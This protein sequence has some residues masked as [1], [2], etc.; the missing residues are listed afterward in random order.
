MFIDVPF[1]TTVALSKIR[2]W[3]F[4]RQNVD[5]KRGNM[6]TS[7]P[8]C[9]FSWS[10]ETHSTY[11]TQQSWDNSV[12]HRTSGAGGNGVSHTMRLENRTWMPRRLKASPVILGVK[13]PYIFSV[14]YMWPKQ[15]AENQI[16]VVWLLSLCFCSYVI[17][18]MLHVAFHVLQRNIVTSKQ[19][20]PS[21]CKF[22]RACWP[23]LATDR[24][25]HFTSLWVLYT[26][27]LR[28]CLSDCLA[29]AC[30]LLS[31]IKAMKLQQAASNRII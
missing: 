12:P 3:S 2:T 7:V 11:H 23:K 9:I 17:Y 25:C 28:I 16:V 27:V 24:S 4:N 20:W 10:C 26:E 31:Q 8:K 13:W 21:V 19:I 5:I 6:C 1:W 22:L 15:T 18:C 14:V 30:V 29:C